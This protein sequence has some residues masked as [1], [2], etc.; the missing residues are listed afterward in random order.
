MADITRLRMSTREL[1]FSIRN[2][3]ELPTLGDVKMREISSSDAY[4]AVSYLYRDSMIRLVHLHASESHFISVEEDGAESQ[5][6]VTNTI[7]DMLS[8][9]LSLNGNET[10]MYNEAL[11]I[12]A[13][14][15]VGL[16]ASTTV[17]KAVEF[18]SSYTSLSS[19][20]AEGLVSDVFEAEAQEHY[21]AYSN[22]ESEIS[23]V[24]FLKGKSYLWRVTPSS[25][26]GCLIIKPINTDVY[27]E[28]V[29][30]F[31]EEMTK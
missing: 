4:V 2:Q 22:K 3:V 1:I 30:R 16:I 25:S 17:P 28:S 21:T 8:N 26:E 11:E 29:K 20:F 12:P 19:Q 31:L 27:C 5:V 7:N 13:N 6:I 15:F 24:K 23:F 14:I 18:L 9:L 10:P